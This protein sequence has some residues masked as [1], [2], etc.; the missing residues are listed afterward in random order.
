MHESDFYCK[1][2]VLS[3]CWGNDSCHGGLPLRLRATSMHNI[4]RRFK[5]TFWSKRLYFFSF[6]TE[7]KC[8]LPSLQEGLSL[9]VMNRMFCC[10]QRFRCWNIHKRSWACVPVI[11]IR[12]KESCYFEHSVNLG[13]NKALGSLSISRFAPDARRWLSLFSTPNGK[14]GLR[15]KRPI[16]VPAANSSVKI[17]CSN[18][19]KNRKGC[20]PPMSRWSH[21]ADRSESTTIL[22]PSSCAGPAIRSQ[23]GLCP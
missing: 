15:V 9:L 3:F 6:W 10:Q 13:L 23:R 7:M 16:A 21:F 12:E 11:H 2:K 19:A 4:L 20:V 18:A 8:F 22:A 14:A 5:S 1:G 17:Q